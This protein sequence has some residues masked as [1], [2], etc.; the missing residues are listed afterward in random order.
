[1]VTLVLLRRGESEWNARL[2][3]PHYG[4]PQ[5]R[6]RRTVRVQYGDEQFR[7]LRRGYDAPPPRCSA[8]KH[9]QLCGDPGCADVPREL[10]SW[11]EDLADVVTRLLP[12]W[13]EVIAPDLRA[14]RTVLVCARGN[15]L[16]ALIGVLDQLSM[17]EPAGL[18]L[19]TGMPLVYDLDR[20]LSPT[21]GGGH[22]LEPEAAHRADL[23]VAGQGR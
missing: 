9:R 17:D 19:P 22:H 4:A 8:D 15:S 7:A 16:R 3:E 14:G 12:H 21:V 13:R 6:D 1:M 11:S 10:L 18:R 2:N 20:R 5:G 23:E